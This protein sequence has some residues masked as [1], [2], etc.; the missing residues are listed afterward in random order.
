MCVIAGIGLRQGDLPDVRRERNRSLGR[1]RPE[2]VPAVTP[3]MGVGDLNSQRLKASNVAFPASDDGASS[4]LR[5]RRFHAVLDAAPAA[6][7]PVIYFQNG[8]DKDY[9]E[10]GGQCDEVLSAPESIMTSGHVNRWAR[11]RTAVLTL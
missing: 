2:L 11:R 9:V 10:A 7:V 4:N 6:G 1:Q 5:V 3:N 8:W